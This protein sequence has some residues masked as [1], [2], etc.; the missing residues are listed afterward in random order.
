MR[1]RKRDEK[2][3]KI[4]PII[5][6]RRSSIDRES[7]IELLPIQTLDIDRIRTPSCILCN[8]STL[9]VW[10]LQVLRRAFENI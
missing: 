3:S 6:M 8:V 9:S 5:F 1:L 4:V 10:D 7:D 2:V